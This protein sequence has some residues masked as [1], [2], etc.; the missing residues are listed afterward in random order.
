MLK[1]E[2]EEELHESGT[3]GLERRDW[4]ARDKIEYRIRD[5]LG[6]LYGRLMG[7]GG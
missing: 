4:L 6:A 1:A 2:E 7:K 5:S 3:G